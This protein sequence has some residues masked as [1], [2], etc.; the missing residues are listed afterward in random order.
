MKI[1]RLPDSTVIRLPDTTSD[2]AMDAIARS[3]LRDKALAERH[4]EAIQ[5]QR[6]LHREALAAA[7]KSS[8]ERSDAVEALGVKIESAIAG[9]A[10]VLTEQDKRLAGAVAAIAEIVSGNAAAL[11]EIGL[12]L[13]ETAKACEAANGSVDTLVAFVKSAT[14]RQ[15]KAAEAFCDAVRARKR[16]IRKDGIIVGVETDA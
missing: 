6:D 8:A 11:K 10:D 1:A 4:R 7:A 12:A 15:E 13:K 9:V 14:A 5:S 3:V 2:E 16:V